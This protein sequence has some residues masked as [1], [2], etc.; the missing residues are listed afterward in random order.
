MSIPQ[1]APTAPNEDVL[2]EYETFSATLGLSRG[3]VE[4][5]RRL[6]RQFLVTHP[7]LNAWMASPMPARVTDL[8][9]VKAWPLIS[10]MVLSGRLRADIDLLIGRHLGGMHRCA[11][12]LAPAEFAFVGDAAVRLG[13]KP[14][15][16]ST[17]MAES[18]TLVVA[19]TGRSPRQL[20]SADID[21]VASAV[22]ASHAATP[23]GRLRHAK[24]LQ[25]LRKVLFEAGVVD[26]PAPPARARLGAQGQLARVGAPEV[27]R[28]MLAYLD[29][30]VAVLR[31]GTIVGIGNDLASFGEFLTERHPGLASLSSLERRHVEGFFG[32]LPHRSRRRHLAGGDR[33]LSVVAVS[34]AIITLRTFLEDITAWGWADAP[35][36]QLIYANDIPRLPKPLPRALPPDVDQA[37]MAAVS[38]LDD[39]FARAG[40]TIIRGTGL[41]V[42]E[43]VDLELGCVVD[44]GASGTWLRVPLGKLA[45]ERS[46][47][48]DDHTLAAFDD[49]MGHR[50]RHRALPH[51]RHGRPVDFL[52]VE[53]GQRLGTPRLR[54]GLELGVQRTGLTGTDGNPPRITPHQLRHTYATTLANGGMSLQGLMIL[55]GHRSPEMTMRYAT[56]AS[57]T[58]RTA[59]EEAIGKLRPRIAVA[60]AGRAPV[61][62]RV[63]WLR[64]EM[65]KT[66]VAHGYCSRDL[67]ADACPYANICEQCENYVTTTEFQP[68]L[69]HQLADVRLLEQDAADRGWSSEAARHARVIDSLERH[70]RRLKNPGDSATFA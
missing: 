50:G 46:V 27:R 45:T 49:W 26:Q 47:P 4:L 53:H 7:D 6:A 44:Y 13:W 14:R 28:A 67:V 2:G 37:V 57:P 54:R 16:V 24:S 61:P 58:L 15:W 40:L 48:L 17:V 65:L 5:R 60:P 31:P 12:A 32:W 63:E 39:P 8:R 25:R 55:L 68:A 29:A 18:L 59:Y 1:L 70:L 20:T 51:P 21:S 56:L 38:S 33:P 64:G 41:R 35:G 10:W 19:F 52:F 36:R 69:E 34:K 23:A 62:D 42:G 30:R 9:R 43:L 66:R 22:E 11:E 3:A